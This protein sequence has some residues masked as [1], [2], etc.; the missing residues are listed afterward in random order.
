MA[1]LPPS[2]HLSCRSAR[3]PAVDSRATCRSQSAGFPAHVRAPSRLR[4]WTAEWV[5]RHRPLALAGSRQSGTKGEFTPGS[6]RSRHQSQRIGAGGVTQSAHQ[7]PRL[8]ELMPHP[9]RHDRVASGHRD[10]RKGVRHLP[11]EPVRSHYYLAG[12]RLASFA[13]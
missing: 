2:G 6:C 7:L 13:I 12:M 4:R 1:R 8:G 10:P 3:S 5:V 11:G 9:R